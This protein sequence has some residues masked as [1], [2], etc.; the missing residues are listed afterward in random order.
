MHIIETQT[1]SNVAL[2]TQLHRT[3]LAQRRGLWTQHRLL[4]PNLPEGLFIFSLACTGV[5][6]LLSFVLLFVLVLG[7]RSS[8]VAFLRGTEIHLDREEAVVFKDAKK[9]ENQINK[10]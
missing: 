9:M 3:R 5:P 4:G 7:N 2:T 6:V 10:K 8:E 1:S